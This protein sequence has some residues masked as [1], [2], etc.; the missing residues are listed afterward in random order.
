MRLLYLHLENYINIYHGLGRTSIDIDFSKC[1]HKVLIELG[2]NGSGKSSIFKAISPF[3][4]DSSVFIPDVDVKKIISYALNDGTNLTITYTA[5]KGIKTRSKPSRCSIIRSY[6]NGNSFELNENGN[7]TSGK[8]IIFD[9]LDLNDDYIVLSAISAT[10]K[11][12]GDLTPSERK[13]YVSSIL[14]AISEYSDMY[15]LFSSKLVVL[16]SL[17][18]SIS[19]KLS[20]IGSVELVQKSINDDELSLQELINKRNQLL[21]KIAVSQSKL[22]DIANI[23]NS[24][25]VQELQELIKRKNDLENNINKIPKDDL[26][27]YTEQYI[28]EITEL[29][30]KLSSS[31]E[32][33][34]ERM[35][36]I[37]LQEEIIQ[38]EIE[39]DKIKLSNMHNQDIYNQL[40][41]KLSLLNNKVVQYQSKFLSLGFNNYN[42]ISESEY[43]LV[44]SSIERF[45]SIIEYLGDNYDQS[46]REKALDDNYRIESYDDMKLSLQNELDQLI[47]EENEQNKL[48]EISNKF[49]L[50]PKD[51][52][53]LNSCP[54]IEDIIRSKKL[55]IGSDNYN[56]LIY[57]LENIENNLKEIDDI[58]KKN[59]LILD[60]REKYNNILSII[61]PIIKPLSY[62]I[63]NITLESLKYNFIHLIK[64][65]I[66]IESY[67]EYSNYISLIQSTNEDINRL[68]DDIEKLNSDKEFM[69]LKISIQKLQNDL[70]TLLKN[71]SDTMIKLN[72]VEN[73]YK[74]VKNKYERITEIKVFKEEYSKS[75]SEL[76]GVQ[77]KINLI[78]ENA[79]KFKS[80]SSELSILQSEYDNLDKKDIPLIQSNLEKSK[81]QLILYE[82]YR[83]EY[84][85]YQDKFNKLQIL[86]RYSSIN[87]I[88]TIYMGVFMNSI[89]QEANEL[90]S[91]LF[92]GRFKLQPFEINET[93]FVIPCIDDDGNIRP[94]I[95]LMS[96]SQ[97]SEISMIISFVLLHK[98]SQA[99]NII[100][101]DEVDDNLDNENRLQFTILINKI[102]E[103]L[104]F[105]QCIIISHNNELDISNADVI[106]TRIEDN[107]HRRNILNSGANIIAD[108]T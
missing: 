8:E 40:K 71:K 29:H 92:K 54:F 52:N 94:D 38:K 18:K 81:Y 27:K 42:N 45:N 80:I 50:I 59:Q 100:K 90:L 53:N 33:L 105:E 46:I 14:S 36:E 39:S 87:G 41:E 73:N 3:M 11:G 77:D 24:N 37:V 106:I 12:L 56:N 95:S 107:E 13:K 75:S 28:L 15:K 43:E 49:S 99:Y 31:Y 32:L 44:L 47:K 61:S 76:K 25:L 5:Y 16:K 62:F 91:L 86:K 60:C 1:K 64:L 4:D 101:L 20:Q 6:P 97:L 68:R 65:D 88:Q 34:N 66:D 104:N 35:K 17:L 102:M 67:Q 23:T 51:C 96:D 48:K 21:N 82:Q 26:D 7:I 10:N 108:F 55:F 89:L 74:E 63:S 78:S 30:A 57:N 69:T 84:N 93:G 79:I 98:A 83:H 58:Q 2:Q 103:M 72:E 22:N 19:V 70:E 9:L 85:E